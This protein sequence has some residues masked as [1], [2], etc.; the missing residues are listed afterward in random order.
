VL[1]AYSMSDTDCRR[2]GACCHSREGTILITEEDILRWRRLGRNDLIDELVEGH[3]G[4]QAFPNGPRGACAHLGIP[5]AP[6]DCSIY[7]MRATVCRTFQPGSAQC[8]EARRDG[9]LG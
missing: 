9:K 2:C 3:F 1:D 5:G 7:Q 4:L 8:L 6:N